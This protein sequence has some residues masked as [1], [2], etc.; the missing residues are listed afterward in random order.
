MLL[1]QLNIPVR[2][3]AATLA[4]YRRLGVA[5]DAADDQFH[6]AVTF[7]NGLDVEFDRDDLVVQWN[8]GFDGRTGGSVVLGFALATKDEVDRLSADL[9][10]A[11]SDGRQPPYDAFWGA[12]YAMV[13]DPDGNPVGLMSPIDETARFWPPSEPPRQGYE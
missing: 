1:N 4:F 5:I 10:A 9:T 7:P 2:D 8:T 12:R 11:G 6:V 3:M 13:D